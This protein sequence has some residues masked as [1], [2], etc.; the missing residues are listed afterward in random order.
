MANSYGDWNPTTPDARA[1]GCKHDAAKRAY[2]KKFNLATDADPAGGTS[3]KLHVG[4]VRAGSCIMPE[5]KIASTVNESG[6]T[7]NLGTLADDDYFAAAVTGPAA[8]ATVSGHILP[9]VQGLVLAV[10]TDIYLTPSGN[11]AATGVIVSTIEA[12]HR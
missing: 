12:S 7:F 10:D 3:N 4:R 1:D 9:A 8:N 2:V 11:L 6:I 5:F